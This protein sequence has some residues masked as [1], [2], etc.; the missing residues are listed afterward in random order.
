VSVPG[1]VDDWFEA[2]PAALE[3]VGLSRDEAERAAAMAGIASVRVMDLDS[4]SR[5]YRETGQRVA[6]TADL[7][8]TRLNLALVDGVVVRAAYF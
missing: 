6:Y 5:R 7:R 8:P 3:F 4:D 2:H 1:W